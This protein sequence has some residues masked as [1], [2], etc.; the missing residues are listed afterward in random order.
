MHLTIKND[1]TL[2]EKDLAKV[3]KGVVN[4]SHD[5]I[6]VLGEEHPWAPLW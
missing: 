1:K 2:S 5:G 4:S 6:M 3:H